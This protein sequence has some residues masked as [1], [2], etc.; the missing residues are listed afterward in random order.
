MAYHIPFIHVAFLQDSTAFLDPYNNN[1]V[2]TVTL[3][4]SSSSV[5]GI[6]PPSERQLLL[7]LAGND[8]LNLMISLTFAR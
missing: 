7:A 1:D 6:T 5:W 4:G 2:K 3:S 8:S